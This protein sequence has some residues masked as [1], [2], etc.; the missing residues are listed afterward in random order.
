MLANNQTCLSFESRPLRHGPD[1]LELWEWTIFPGEEFRSR[2]HPAGTLE[3]LA[4]T[5]G[6]LA[7]E[8]DDVHHLVAA[9]HRAVSM[10][11]RPHAYRCHGK[12]R[13]RF[14]MVVQE[15]AST[16]VARLGTP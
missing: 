6:V 15:P 7:L 13:V 1:M 14:T 12:K 8:V 3:I 10:A 4:V 5:E 9:N 11:D 16:E 2:G